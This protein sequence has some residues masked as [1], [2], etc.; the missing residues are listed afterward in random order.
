[1]DYQIGGP[2]PPAPGTG[3]VIRDRTTDPVPG[4]YSICYVNAFQAQPHESDQWRGADADLLLANRTGTLVQDRVW[5]EPL[6]DIST[7]GKRELLA[8]KV[9]GW[10]AECARKGF[11]AVEPDNLDSWTRSAGLLTRQDAVS[12]A[13]LLAERAHAAGLAVGQKNAAELTDAEIRS[14][15][16]DFAVAEDCQRHG[17]EGATECERY[18]AVHGEN[19]I[20]IE[21]SD[22]GRRAFEAACRARG[23]RIS[24]LLRD[25]DVVPRGTPGY[26]NRTC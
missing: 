15:G 23:D 14:V 4:V 1:M 16:F 11:R 25:R 5:D 17:W 18:M 21:Y 9:G 12:Y 26:E 10:M 8:E 24:I 3:V 20:E 13:R 7:P 22:E 19:V 2:Y 6:L